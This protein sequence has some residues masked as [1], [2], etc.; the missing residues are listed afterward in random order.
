MAITDD[1]KASVESLKQEVKDIKE[2]V[3]DLVPLRRRARQLPAQNESAGLEHPVL[4]LQRATNQLFDRY[5]Q[6]LGWPLGAA[7]GLMDRLWTQ[8]K[9]DWPRLD[10]R[11]T[12]SAIQ[13][14]ADLPGVDKDNIEVSVQG[15]RLIIRGE[16]R[17]EDERREGNYYQVERSY[18]SFHRQVW[19]PAEVNPDKVEANYKDGVLTID[20][21]KTEEVK[22]KTKKIAVKSE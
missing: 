11:E 21:P 15:D 8:E 1:L 10:L 9:W 13:V 2:R 6:E 4:S 19:L 17:S 5:W 3:K 7:G 12:D 22:A 18:G 16:K 20:L 14:T